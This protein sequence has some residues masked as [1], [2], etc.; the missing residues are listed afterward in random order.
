MT[1]MIFNAL[2]ETIYMS[3][4]S[5]AIAVIF[6]LPLGIF[7]CITKPNGIMPMP[8]INYAL[9]WVV[10]VVRSFPFLIL[11]VILLP[12]M[13]FLVG[14]SVG[15]TPAIIPLSIAATPFIARLFEG[16]LDEIDK[17]LIEASR[18]LGASHFEI[19][20]M[21]VFEALPQLVNS[22]TITTISLIGYSAMAGAVGAGGLGNLAMMQGY[23]S[24]RADILLWAVIVT[25]AIV[26]VVQV[27]GDLVVK[28]IRKR[29]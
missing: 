21:M 2:L 11:I 18:S 25:I 26:Q 22:I 28:L 15:N 29:R 1:W 7:L 24:F 9:G 17:G 8:A 13:R 14:S 6:G 19:I 27:S 12:Y 10:N 3:A 4:V 5:C 16:A 20:K 23:H